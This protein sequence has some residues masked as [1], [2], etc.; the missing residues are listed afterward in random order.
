MRQHHRPLPALHRPTDP[1]NMIHCLSRSRWLAENQ[2]KIK[3]WTTYIFA[4]LKWWLP[5]CTCQFLRTHVLFVW[6][7]TS[8]QH[9]GRVPTCHSAHSW[10]LYSDVPL[11]GWAGCRHRDP[12]YHLVTSINLVCH[13]LDSTGDSNSQPYAGKSCNLT[14]L[15]IASDW[16]LGKVC[17][18]MQLPAAPNTLLLYYSQ[19]YISFRTR[20][21][22]EL[23]GSAN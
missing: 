20:L 13:W 17:V 21:L 7:F 18:D 14:D 19:C 23:Y 6:G 15:A 2:S 16:V 8:W 12:I 9:P 4:A 22:T 3:A 5:Q 1:P 10:R 11:G